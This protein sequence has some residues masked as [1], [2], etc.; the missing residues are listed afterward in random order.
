[1]IETVSFRLNDRPVRL[2]VDPKRTLLWVLRTELELT[3]AKHGCGVSECGACTVLVN[4]RPV[5]ACGAKIKSVAG[6][7]VVT[8]EGLAKGTAL[9]PLQQAFVEHD[10]LQCGFCTPGMI[11]SAYGFLRT[12]PNPTY[13]DVLKGMDRNLCRCGAH[14]RIVE[15]IL[16]AAA[17]MREATVP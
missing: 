6:K 11:L 13:E 3:G 17:A 7:E 16:A 1:M 9:H 14:K 15:A 10:A 8:I 4:D 2:R 5:R 12:H